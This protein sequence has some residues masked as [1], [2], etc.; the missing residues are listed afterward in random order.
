MPEETLPASPDWVND[1][2]VIIFAGDD[3]LAVGAF[4]PEGLGDW[5]GNIFGRSRDAVKADWDRVVGQ[6]SFFLEHVTLVSDEFEMSEVTFQL[7]FTAEGQI[8]FVAKAGIQTTLTA[9]FTRKKK[10]G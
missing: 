5:V 7:G 2:E 3:P 4:R 10:G 1:P 8:A 6:M 9:K